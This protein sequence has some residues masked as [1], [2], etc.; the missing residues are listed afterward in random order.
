[1][2]LPKRDQLVLI[3]S[4]ISFFLLFPKL[5]LGLLPYPGDLLVSFYFPWYSGHWPGYDSWTFHKEF[6]ASDAIRQMIPWRNLAINLLK[7]G[8]WPLWNPYNFAGT[9][10]LAN[11]QTAI[12]HPTSLLFFLM[13]FLTAWTVYIMLQPVL[14]VGFTYLYSRSSLHLSRASSLLAGLAFAT[15]SFILMWFELGIIGHAIAWL[16]F[17]LFLIDRLLQHYRLRYLLALVIASIFVVFSGHVQSIVNVFLV[18]GLYWLYR[19]FTTNTPKIKRL[20]LITIFCWATVTAGLS[21]V[22][23]LPALELQHLSPM[24]QG[25]AKDVFL[26]LK[27]PWKN[28]LTF[29]APDYFGHPVTGNYTSEIYGDGTP[30]FGVAAFILAVYA[31]CAVKGKKAAFFKLLFFTYLLYTFPGPIFHLVRLTNLPVFSQT[32]EAR[33]F[34]VVIFAGSILAAMGLHQLT[35]HYKIRI[36]KHFNRIILIFASI[37]LA[38]LISN[39]IISK[40]P[41]FFGLDPTI[42]NTSFR[43]LLLPSLVFFILA[44]AYFVTVSH[45]RGKNFFLAAVLI[46]QLLLAA[47][48]INKTL[49]FSPAK[50]FYPDHLVI[51][52]LKRL[53]GLNRFLG[54]DT[55]SFG[56]NFATYYQI[57]SPTGYDN[58]RIQRFAQL[59]AAQNTGELPDKYS[60]SDADF[61]G[62][63]DFR[64]RRLLS[65]LSTKYFLDKYDDETLAWNPEPLKFHN[66]A[67]LVWQEGIFKIYGRPASLP[68][69]YLTSDYLTISDPAAII[70]TLLTESFDYQ[71]QVIL[72]ETLPADF[73]L[74]PPENQTLAITNYQPNTVE[75]ATNTNTNTLLTLTDAD[76]PG[77]HAYVNNQETKIYR[78]NYALRTIMLPKGEN[79]VTFIYKPKSFTHGFIISSAT[80]L[81]LPIIT[82]YSLYRKKISW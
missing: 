24:S 22:Q 1:M 27:T 8:Q 37:Y 76:F 48:Q 31:I 20:H 5:L 26:H 14:M 68:R 75:I 64:S 50:F 6:I 42:A 81:A 67:D 17:I 54:V 10:L 11:L 9:P 18:S 4:V 56:T 79:R 46:P 47:Y 66:L 71:H 39:F 72:E 49:P 59:V 61:I 57:Y 13:P 36:A 33:S 3:F 19:L 70:R 40:T 23:F 29:L 65:L 78:S 41:G 82:S 43:N 51:D 34:F 16:P 25:F 73:V 53:A 2:K 35:H 77:W 60:K 38:L 55:A 52:N 44:L 7:Q 58:M 32:L 30:F 28:I 15:A 69:A 62:K 80:L 45:K 21:A 63:D 74:S 12:F